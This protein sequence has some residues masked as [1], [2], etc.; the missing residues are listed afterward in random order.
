MSR[1]QLDQQTSP[2]LLLHKDNPVHWRPWGPEALDEAQTIGKPILLSIGFTA[3]HWCHVM[4][5]ESFEDPEAAALMNE[6]FVNIKV[7]R[8]ER[9]DLDQVYQA[10]ANAMGHGGGWPLT[11]F[12]TPNGEP[13]FAAAYLPKDE[14]NGQPPF[15]TLLVDLAKRY[16][17]QPDRVTQAVAQVQQSFAMLWA[18]DLR[19]E[20]DGPVLDQV[21]VHV[22]QR[23]DLF[24]GGL[25]GTQKFPVP[26]LTEMLWRAYLR[27]GF[28]H[29]ATL[30]QQTLDHQ[31][32]G[33]I[34]DHVGGGFCR[35]SADERWLIPHFEKML[36]DNASLVDVMTLVWQHN[37]PPLY[38]ARIE[39]TI[40][41]V[42]RDMMVESA[43][44]C[45][46]D[47]DIDAALA[48]TFAQKFKEVYN[49]RREGTFQGRNVLQRT[50][51]PFPLADA[52][53]ALLKRQRELLLAVRQKRTAPARD[54]KVLA[55]W[56]GMMI[57]A[58]AN[59]GAVFRNAKW[60]TAAAQAFDFI[61][62]ALGDGDRLYHSWREG[63]R[64]HTGF[65]DDY[66]QMARAA[67]TLF[68]A[69]GDR[70]YL[71]Q[72]E[73]WVRVLNEHFWD[74]QLGGYF[75]TSDDSDPLIVRSRLVFDQNAPSANGV[76][77]ALLGR[78]F[79]VTADQAYRDRCNALIQSF[80]AE[81]SRVPISMGTYLN[82]L[83]VAVLGQ[84]IVIIGPLN[85][86]K[87][88][89][90]VSAV[91]G[92]SLPNLT[93]IVTDPS[94]PLPEGHP[95]AGKGM[96]NGQPTAYVCQRMTVTSPITNPVTLSQMLNL[97]P[98]VAGSA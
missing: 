6:L 29:F 13:Y 73:K 7:D 58:L 43:F 54:D 41:W 23:F 31:C 18:R 15:K 49:V 8:E 22:G 95:A 44:A 48:G 36:Y 42:L 4:N 52:D 38:R 1:N 35:H 37:R 92:R 24:Y 53:E 64:G 61:V 20:F 26:G 47:A 12:L 63:K 80:A 71:A 11:M 69:S 10:A 45:S 76:M 91:R 97:P 84:V 89:E 60:L 30:V 9:P 94:Q 19:A 75:F 98:K 5:H 67:F 3:C 79:F 40:E 57:S 65:A 25:L 72:T 88:H 87:T 77:V 51:R 59:A 28:I 81:V 83:E 39:E 50:G 34:Y 82:S 93:L 21:G 78:L 32:L 68:E 70:R 96:L 86:P 90:L 33:G 56:N 66:A 55:D 62:K 46:I 2:Y 27:T 16:T 85:H 17:E 14:R 74:S